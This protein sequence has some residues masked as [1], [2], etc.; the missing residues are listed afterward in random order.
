[1]LACISHEEVQR[2][3]FKLYRNYEQGRKQREALA[4]DHE[5][6]VGLKALEG[7]DQTTEHVSDLDL[8]GMR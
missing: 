8:E 7:Q 4:A 1:M 3:T 5:D 6:E 2:E